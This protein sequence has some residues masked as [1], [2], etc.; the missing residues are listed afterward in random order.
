MRW[1]SFLF[2]LLVGIIAIFVIRTRLFRS[3]S[4]SAQPGGLDRVVEEVRFDNTPLEAALAEL[5]KKSAC[6]IHADWEALESIG[7]RPTTPVRLHL[8]NVPMETALDLLLNQSSASLHGEV[9]SIPR[10]HNSIEFTIRHEANRKPP[11]L[12]M[13]DVAMIMYRLPWPAATPQNVNDRFE[14]MEFLTQVIEIA[15]SESNER[16]AGPSPSMY[17]HNGRLFVFQ[18]AENH[19]IVEHVIRKLRLVQQ[20]FDGGPSPATQPFELMKG[21]F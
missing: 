5:S 9:K 3:R 19:R 15:V 11:E 7:A 1:K 13:Y 10:S 12:R 2:L 18:T 14:H 6:P 8:F 17:E 20:A 4:Q 21:R 16:T